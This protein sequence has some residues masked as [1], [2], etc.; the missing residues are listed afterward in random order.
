MGEMKK[1]LMKELQRMYNLVGE[2]KGNYLD[3]QVWDS[4]IN[5]GDASLL[6]TE[7]QD[8]LFEIYTKARALNISRANLPR[9][10]VDDNRKITKI[11]TKVSYEALQQTGP[12]IQL[13]QLCTNRRLLHLH[14]QCSFSIG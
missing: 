4:L 13:S 9:L 5:S 7:L 11:I 6:S 1:I 14:G 2:R 12:S 10:C 8:V 3:T